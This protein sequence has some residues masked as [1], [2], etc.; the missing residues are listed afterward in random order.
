MINTKKITVGSILVLISYIIARTGVGQPDGLI[1]WH[2][3]FSGLFGVIGII[4]IAS[5]S[6]GD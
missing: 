5:L 6:D 2:G 4:F 3:M 1:V